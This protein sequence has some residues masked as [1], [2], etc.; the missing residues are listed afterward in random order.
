[1]YVCMYVCVCVVSMGGGVPSML[2]IMTVFH[3][4]ACAQGSFKAIA[5]DFECV[6]CPD[7]SN[8]TGGANTN[9]TCNQGYIQAADGTC[10]GAVYVRM[11]VCMHDVRTYVYDVCAYSV[12][13]V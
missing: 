7:N 13:Y 2:Y 8:N 10:S 1:M 11:C 12:T 9:C 3:F 5:G 4:S 6:P